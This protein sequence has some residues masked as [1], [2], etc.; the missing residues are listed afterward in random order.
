M[1]LFICFA[2]APAVAADNVQRVSTSFTYSAPATLSI[3][4]VQAGNMDTL[5]TDLR[6]S[7]LHKTSDE[8]SLGLGL[9]WERLGFGLP[10]GVPLP[11][12]VQS[13]SLNFENNWKFAERWALRFS[14]RPGIYS[15]MEE[16]GSRDFNM[17]MLVGLSYS[18][19]A[20]LSWVAAFNV[21]ARR[22]LP[23]VGGLGVRWQFAEAWTL[24]LLLP[25]PTLEYQACSKATV[26]VGGELTGG[27]WRVS[28]NLGTRT[29]S[30]AVN[31]QM[32]SYREIRAGAGVRTKVGERLNVILEGGWVI[33]RRFVYDKA[34]LLF[35]GKGAP[36]VSL[37]VDARF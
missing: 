36:Y 10:G 22:D 32:V 23:V 25:K 21:D 20:D 28:E 17:P 3:G 35:N 19:R 30:P 12:T 37:S 27:A 1:C 13:L 26:F 2:C 5:R 4:S 9:G 34:N 16:I 29:G 15:D 11:N 14:A 24:S 18:P 8:Y 33:D 7:W 31:D 6:Y